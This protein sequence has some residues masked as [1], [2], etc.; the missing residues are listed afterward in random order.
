MEKGLLFTCW[1]CCP[2]VWCS[3]RIR[4][5]VKSTLAAE[6]LALID[7]LDTALYLASILKEVLSLKCLPI[8]CHTDNNSLCENLLS[9]KQVAEKCLRIDIVNSINWI[10][11]DKQLADGLTKR[12]ASVKTLVN[13]LETGHFSKLF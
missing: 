13:V 9:T 12:W 2:L 11:A 8:D 3:K 10:T 4:R 5:V 7:C 6:T 1:R